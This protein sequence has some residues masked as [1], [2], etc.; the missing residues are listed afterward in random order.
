M[1]VDNRVA[2]KQVVWQE[3]TDSGAT[4]TDIVNSNTMTHTFYLTAPG[5][6]QARVKMTNK[7]TLVDSFTDP[8]EVWA[9]SKLSATIT[10]PNNMAPGD[11]A[12]FSSVLMR[13]GVATTDTVNEWTLVAPSGT[14][15]TTGSTT[16]VTE[17]KPGKIYITLKTRP[18]DTAANDPNAW[19]VASDYLTVATPGRPSLM[20]T[21]SKLVEV[22]KTYAYSG[23]VHPSWG[24]AAS[25]DNIITQW[26]LPDGTVVPGNQLSWTPTAN[27]L[28]IAHPQVTFSAWVN[29]FR[30]ATT[31][32]TTINVSPWLYIWPNWTIA[33]KQATLQAPADIFLLVNHDTPSMNQHFDGLTYTWSF[34]DGVTGLQSAAF[35]NEASGQAVYAGTYNVQV[36]IAD[37]RGNQTVLTQ[38]VVAAQAKPYTVTLSVFDSNIYSR[39]PMNVTVRP[40]ITGGHP[41]DQVIS[42]NWSV[43][44]VVDSAYI[45]RNFL[46]TTIPEPGSHIV[47]YTMNSKMGQTVTVNTPV[48]L[49][50]NQPPTCTLSAVPNAYVVYAEAKCTDVDGKVVGYAWQV[51]GQSIASSSYRVSFSKL[52]PPQSASVTIIA[53]DDAGATSTPTSITVSY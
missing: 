36:T 45:N 39:A 48:K 10:G 30:S 35:P 1:T 26:T 28:A 29:G 32:S 20:V 16:S 21:G 19:T 12:I 7:N 13:N 33:V 17:T 38:Q 52:G 22:G 37:N 34:P 5:K 31:V 25:V 53:T 49:V 47:S 50:P 8:V 23:T 42:Q 44:G 14:T 40:T 24:G 46:Y 41:L 9:Y 3:S 4:W 11:T 6:R 51:N 43:D 15:T 18:S 2:T 27:D